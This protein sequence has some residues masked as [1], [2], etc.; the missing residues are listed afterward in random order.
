MKLS[1]VVVP[2]KTYANS[3][4]DICVLTN[5]EGILPGVKRQQAFEL[6]PFQPSSFHLCFLKLM[7][8]QRGHPTGGGS[9]ITVVSTAI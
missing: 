2:Q 4:C 9:L 6:S 8:P 1:S 7:E 5:S 3:L